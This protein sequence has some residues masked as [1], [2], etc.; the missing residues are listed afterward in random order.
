MGSISHCGQLW[1]WNDEEEVDKDEDAD[2]KSIL[3]FSGY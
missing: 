1:R 3:K 2:D